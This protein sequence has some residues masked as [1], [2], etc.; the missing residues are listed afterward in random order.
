MVEFS[1][2]G[3]PVTKKRKL[4]LGNRATRIRSTTKPIG[5]GTS[6]VPLEDNPVDSIIRD[7]KEIR[8]RI[9][10][11]ELQMQQVGELMGNPPWDSLVAAIQETIQDPRR[12]RGLERKVDHLTEEKRK[13]ADQVRKLEAERDKLLKKVRI[14]PSR[15]KK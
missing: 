12:L 7:L 8:S 1:S 14:P 6:T 2:E 3:R 5:G 9:A 4:M 11:Y 13:T 10:E 15:Y